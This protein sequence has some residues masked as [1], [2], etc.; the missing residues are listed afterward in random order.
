MPAF[1]AAQHVAE[2]VVGKA[3]EETGG[4]AEPPEGDGGVEDR[5]AGIGRIGRLAERRLARQH[6]DQSFTTA[7]DHCQPSPECLLFNRF[8]ISRA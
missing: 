7:Q 1:R 6:I 5:T 2:H 8:R 4:N 3:G